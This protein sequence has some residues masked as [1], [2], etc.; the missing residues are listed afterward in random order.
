VDAQ[1]AANDEA[2]LAAVFAVDSISLIVLVPTAL[3]TLVFW[4]RHGKNEA[5]ISS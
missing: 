5:N 1:S 2:S 3:V 4:N